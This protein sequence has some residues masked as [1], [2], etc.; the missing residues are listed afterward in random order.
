MVWL[1]LLAWGLQ[2]ELKKESFAEVVMGSA[3]DSQE[4]ADLEKQWE[5]EEPD[6]KE[7]VAESLKKVDAAEKRASEAE[8]RLVTMRKVRVLGSHLSNA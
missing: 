4:E 1:T 6:P 3:K 2:Q 8:G 5:F 7:M